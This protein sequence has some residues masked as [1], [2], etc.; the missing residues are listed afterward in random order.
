[1]VV[2]WGVFFSHFV[3]SIF[4]SSL[5]VVFPEATVL[6]YST[7]APVV[8]VIFSGVVGE[9]RGTLTHQW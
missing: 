6:H 3:S 5:L 4:T 7:F 9:S 2:F 1:M 8:E